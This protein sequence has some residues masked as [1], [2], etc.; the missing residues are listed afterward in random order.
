MQTAPTIG[1]VIGGLLGNYAGWRW[2]F[3]FLC[4]ASGL[5][6]ILIVLSLPETNRKIV[7]NGSIRPPKA[8]LLPI[9]RIF[10]H[11]KV[12]N[13]SESMHREWHIPNPIKCI[14]FLGRKDTAL[15][16]VSLGI[17][18][19]STTPHMGMP[20]IRAPIYT[21]ISDFDVFLIK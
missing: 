9:P 10:Q 8:L 7:G 1:P 4:I 17:L 19:K 13:E 6:F 3:W 2:I 20:P 12:E 14:K 15:I 16:I 5:C 21:K 11:W 18:N